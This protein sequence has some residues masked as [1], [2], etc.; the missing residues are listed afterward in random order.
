MLKTK[1]SEAD[2][3]L[4]DLNKW[5]ETPSP[6]MLNLSTPL[7]KGAKLI[8]E[9]EKLSIDTLEKIIAKVKRI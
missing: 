6:D 8:V 3:I 1:K 5:L 9:P 7:A 2:D 4:E